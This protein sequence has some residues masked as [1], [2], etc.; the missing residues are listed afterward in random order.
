VRR[1]GCLLATGLLLAGVAQATN[2]EV[3]VIADRVNL[4]AAATMDAEVVAQVDANAILSAAGAEGEW[5]Q[6][7]APSN[8]GFW[9]YSVFI[10]DGLVLPDKLNVRSGP[11]PNYRSI[12]LLRRGDAVR[13]RDAVGDWIEVDPPPGAMLWVHGSL[14]APVGPKAAPGPVAATG[15]V[16]TAA[17]P[18]EPPGPALGEAAPAFLPPRKVEVPPEI[19]RRKLSPVLG[20]GTRVQREGVVRAV[21]YLLF[22]PSEYQLVRETERGAE[23]ICYLEGNRSQLASLAGRRVQLEGREYWVRRVKQPIVVPEVITPLP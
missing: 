2:S 8:V 19:A 15:V 6:V 23:V 12:V 17:A 16:A 7:V 21:D 18:A 5:V 10:K 4:R 9:V 22:R 13:V 14:V 20:Q 3:R 11:G 1:F